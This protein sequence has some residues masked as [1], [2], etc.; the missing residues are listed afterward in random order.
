MA[1]FFNEPLP[2]WQKL[3]YKYAE[4]FTARWKDKLICVSEFD[5]LAAIN[6]KISAKKLITI[7]N[8]LETDHF[9]DKEL[10]SQIINEKLGR[11]L[12]ERTLLIGT[13]GNLYKTKGYDYLFSAVRMIVSKYKIP[14]ALVVIGS[15]NER[16]D[17]EKLIAE[18]KMENN[19]FI[20]DI[21]EEAWQLLKAFDV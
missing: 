17:L 12:P 10:A 4:K 6:E 13:I 3:F 20:I 15:G 16:N 11:S 7:H 8:G 14:A 1:G 18:L 2:L 9:W 21:K 5:H 19:V